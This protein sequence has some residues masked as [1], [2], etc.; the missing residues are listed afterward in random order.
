MDEKYICIV[1]L[2]CSEYLLGKDLEKQ[3]RCV[4]NTIALT[5]LFV[6]SLGCSKVDISSQFTNDHNIDTL[7]DFTLEGGSINQ[8][9]K[10]LGRS[11]VSKETH[12]GSHL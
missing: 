12:G 2:E 10:D 11:K 7:D 1:F 5:I 4:C 6:N 3:N 8:L 9:R